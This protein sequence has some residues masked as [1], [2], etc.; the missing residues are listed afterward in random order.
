MAEFFASTNLGYLGIDVA[1]WPAEFTGPIILHP[2]LPQGPLPSILC[3]GPLAAT[4]AAVL[5]AV[6][7]VASRTLPS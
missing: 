3:S 7:P 1:G 4:V 6:V 2:K 5:G